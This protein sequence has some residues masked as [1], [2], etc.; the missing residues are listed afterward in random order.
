[1]HQQAKALSDDYGDSIVSLSGKQIKADYLSGTPS[2][3]G[4]YYPN[5]IGI[6]PW[7]FC[8]GL[9][10]KATQAGTKIYG[11]SPVLRCELVNN[12]HIVHTQAGSIEANTL[13]IA[14]NGYGQ[15]KLHERLVDRTFPVISS[16]IVT[17]TLSPEQIESIGMKAGLMAMDTRALKYYY[18]ILPD[19]RL[20]FGGRGAVY[21][22]DAD[23][24]R[25]REALEK[26]LYDTFPNL[27]KV[28]ISYFWSGWVS[29]SIDDTPRIFH[30]KSENMLYSAGYCGA[31]L[32]FAT[33]A[34]KRMA[35][36][37]VEPNTLPDLPYWQTPLRRFPLSALR[38]PAL[39]AFYAWQEL[40]SVF[41]K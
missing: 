29:V 3:G 36:L 23:N 30:D 21:G 12:K 28:D 13:I 39:S 17:Q 9:A 24:K 10:L 19:N 11:N 18:R 15:R 27:P 5:A 1:L 22:K 41:L 7:M 2:Y 37:L 8:Q 31:G 20:L 25:Y 34:G 40:K 6:N 32:A 14:T 38:R 16:I 35:Q 4:I 26:A 33:Q